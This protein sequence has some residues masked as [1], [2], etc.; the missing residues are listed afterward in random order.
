MTGT[1]S[2]PA[3]RA[4]PA[5]WAALCVA[6][7]LGLL[8]GAGAVSLA[9]GYLIRSYLLSHPEVLPEAMQ[10]LRD[11]D[12]AKFVNAYRKQIETPFAGAWAGARDGDVVMVEFFDYACPYCRK[13]NADVARV[14]AEDPKLRLVWREWPVLGPDSQTAAEASLAAARKGRFAAFHDA[15]FAIGRPDSA[16]LAAAQK[17]AGLTPADLASVGKA[18]AGAELARNDDLAR[19][20][21]ATGTPTFVIGDRV[22]QGAVGYDALKKAVADAR[23]R[24]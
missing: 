1:E 8:I 12:A 2:G 23:A 15:L 13:N 5:G 14:L 4:A 16:T 18:E 19:G 11:R 9:N 24:G 3:A 22:L 20:L 6:L 7:L 17:A 10:R 21:G